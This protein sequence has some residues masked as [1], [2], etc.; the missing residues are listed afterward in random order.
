[1]WSHHSR[2]TQFCKLVE[3][4]AKCC[5]LLWSVLSSN[6]YKRCDRQSCIVTSSCL[7]YRIDVN[8]A[9]WLDR[10]VRLL[11]CA[12]HSFQHSYVFANYVDHITSRY[13]YIWCSCV[14]HPCDLVLRFPILRFHPCH[15]VP[16]FPFQRFQPVCRVLCADVFGVTS[17]EGF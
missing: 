15:L 14:F 4:N 13:P 2:S 9:M 6:H 5:F 1:M 17:S 11:T 16:R 8:C 7:L 12:R 10:S 3:I